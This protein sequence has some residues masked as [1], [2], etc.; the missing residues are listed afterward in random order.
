MICFVAGVRFLDGPLTDMIEAMA[1][2]FNHKYIDIYSAS[3][4]PVDNGQTLDGP[5]KMA[6]KA[7]EKGIQEVRK[8]KYKPIF[9]FTLK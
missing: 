3:W 4:G 6:T 2:G 7:F 5:G 8:A 9:S 1:I